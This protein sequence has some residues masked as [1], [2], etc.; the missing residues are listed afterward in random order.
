MSLAGRGAA[1]LSLAQADLESALASIEARTTALTTAPAG[2]A[3]LGWVE[4]LG[5]TPA[6]AAEHLTSMYLLGRALTEVSVWLTDHVEVVQRVVRDGPRLRPLAEAIL[7]QPATG[8]WFGPLDRASQM[9]AWGPGGSPPPADLADLPRPVP[10]RRSPTD[11]ERYAQKPEWGLY[12][13]TAFDGLSAF[14]TGASEEAGDLGPLTL[15]FPRHLLR[16][17]PTARVFEID[18]PDAWRRLCLTYPAP[19]PGGLTGG[20][21]VPD[22]AAVAR[23][24]DGVHVTLGGLLTGD[25]VRL[26][27]PGGATALQGWDTEATVWLRWVFDEV[28]RLPD[29]MEQPPVPPALR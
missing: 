18:G 8:W 3:F 23:D 26:D 6:E 5:I 1:L 28:T 14:V 15:P 21:V 17:S 11:W 7:S 29:L 25:Q 2:C 27:G 9:V 20:L 10:A 22:F 16:I 12:T 13:S 19:E 4:R 24:W